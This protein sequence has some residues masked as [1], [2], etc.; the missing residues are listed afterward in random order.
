V[1]LKES[2]WNKLIRNEELEFDVLEGIEED[3]HGIFRVDP[4]NV[5]NWLNKD[6]EDF[7]YQDLIEEEIAQ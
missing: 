2:A 4:S 3:F 1:K 6:E 5:R 7:G